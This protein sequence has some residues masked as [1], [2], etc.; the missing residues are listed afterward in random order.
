MP[1]IIECSLFPEATSHPSYHPRGR[2]INKPEE[3]VL[4]HQGDYARDCHHNMNNNDNAI[5]TAG[6][7]LQLL[8][9]KG[10]PQDPKP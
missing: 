5:D 9:R 8:L 1:L 4:Q 10:A 3:G 2:Q 7:K 6:T